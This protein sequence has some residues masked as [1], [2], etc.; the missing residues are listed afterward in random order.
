M[1]TI[2]NK[3]ERNS[4][5][6]LIMFFLFFIIQFLN[7]QHLQA[8]D[9]ILNFAD[10]STY[11]VTCGK[12]TSAQ[13][14]VKND[15]CMLFTPYIRAEDEGVTAVDFTFK[16]NQSGNG[17]PFDKGYVF[18][19]T[20]G[21]DWVLDTSWTAG[22]SSAVYS[23]CD[24]VT[25]EYGH[26]VCFMVRLS[27]N[28]KTE[29]WSVL[30]GGIQ[31]SDGIDSEH[32]VEA[33]NE[34]P[35]LLGPDLPVELISFDGHYDNG[36]IFLSWETAS[37][38][39]ND[40]FTLEKS[41]DGIIFF[42]VAYIVGAGNSNSPILYSFADEDPF[43]TTF[44]RLKQTDYDG[45]YSESQIIKINATVKSNDFEIICYNGVLKI[46]TDNAENEQVQINIF[47]IDGKLV[48]NN[49]V[50]IENGGGTISISPEI[51][52]NSVYIVCAGLNNNKP[53][54]SKI[55]FN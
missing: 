47:S 25:L 3:T 32:N 21:G 14:S 39:N 16:V 48:Y 7:S 55:Y 9:Y 29:F 35:P 36:N 26:Y 51:Q 2:T 33:Y 37:E 28:N 52:R 11:M 50:N 18:H 15:T 17:D 23:Y 4:G 54:N 49:V 38:T 44:Y 13:W 10:P 22:T 42:D 12:V 41:D 5:K 20:D 6:I 30:D 1:K 27:T 31:A 8:Q 24:K 19:S 34:E 40:F 46:I 43:E 53:V 45:S